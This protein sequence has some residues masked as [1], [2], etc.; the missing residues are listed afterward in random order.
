MRAVGLHPDVIVV[1]SR[2]YATA[3]VLVRGGDE[4][5]LIDSPVFPDELDV[6]AAVAAQAEFP[7]VGLLATHGDWDHLLGG[8]AF[9]DAPLG[10]AES[11]AARL[12][13]EVG[14]PQR[15]LRAFDEELYVTRPRPL[16]LPGAQ[17]L[18]VPGHVDVGSRELELHPAEGHTV[19]GMALWAPWAGVLI[20]GDYLSPVEIPMISEGG[21]ASA[22]LA[23][24]A[25]LEPLV[26][27]AAH[28][29]PGHGGAIEGERAL[30]ILREDRAYLEALLERGAGA[31]LP[32]ARRTGAQRAIHAKNAERVSRH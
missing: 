6:L 7:V 4:A 22:Y 30:A 24:L 29:V 8:Y 9:P 32:L 26:A 31:P 12:I 16:S 18:P 1:T 13:S 11:T 20:A 19:D 27:Q 2:A 14:T 10:A 23:T 15:E 25:R 17:Q 28:V 5:F 21:S 3:A